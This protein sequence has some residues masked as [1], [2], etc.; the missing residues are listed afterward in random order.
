M[1]ALTETMPNKYYKQFANTCYRCKEQV[2]KQ[3]KDLFF[4]EVSTNK[5][6]VWD[7]LRGGI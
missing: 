5:G 2:A 1:R 7:E 3:T 4:F 6:R